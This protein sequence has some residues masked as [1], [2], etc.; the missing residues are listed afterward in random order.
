MAAVRPAALWPGV[1]VCHVRPAEAS[2]VRGPRR[3]LRARRKLPQAPLSGPIAM[4]LSALPPPSSCLG[5][6]A[7]PH[8]EYRGTAGRARTRWASTP[9]K[10]AAHEWR[11][12]SAPRPAPGRAAAAACSGH[13]PAL[14]TP[15]AFPSSF[16]PR[17]PQGCCVDAHML[18]SPSGSAFSSK[19]NS[20]GMKGWK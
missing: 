5:G 3:S 19:G 6:V 20:E 11:G 2:W 10:R 14:L 1:L 15:D 4:T 18:A 12:R 9:G 17:G 13:L 16:L 7:R 8:A